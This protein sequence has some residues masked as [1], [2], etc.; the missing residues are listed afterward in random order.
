MCE[1]KKHDYAF[2]LILYSIILNVLLLAG[3]TSIVLNALGS[4]EWNAG[5]VARANNPNLVE[6]VK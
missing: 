1:G 4:A 2:W 6:V 5:W 3:M